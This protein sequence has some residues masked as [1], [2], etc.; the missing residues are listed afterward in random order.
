MVLILRGVRCS[1]YI[2]CLHQ[3]TLANISIYLGK[4]SP[5]KI[6]YFCPLHEHALVLKIIIFFWQRAL[7][8]FF[9]L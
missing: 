7:G 9:E 5:L 2:S 3:H 4:W 6:V 8:M 1:F